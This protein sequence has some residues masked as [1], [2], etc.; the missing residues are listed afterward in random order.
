MIC[1]SRL[2]LIACSDQVKADGLGQH[3]EKKRTSDQMKGLGVTIKAR[4]CMTS[5]SWGRGMDFTIRECSVHHIIKVT[6][7]LGPTHGVSP[8]LH[9][10]GEENLQG[11]PVLSWCMKKASR[12]SNVLYKKALSC[13]FCPSQPCDLYIPRMDCPP[14]FFSSRFPDRA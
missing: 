3:E 12:D 5:R 8:Y 2:C 11:W 4:R 6:C 14:F 10:D 7:V 9:C 13:V 1:A